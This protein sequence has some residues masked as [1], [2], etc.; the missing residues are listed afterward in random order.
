ME[1]IAYIIL[2][3][4]VVCWLIAMIAGMIAVFPVG[5]IGLVIMLAFGLLFAKALKERLVSKKED[6]YS[7]DIEK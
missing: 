5:I 1:K 6:R 2:I 7:K 4:A 3:I